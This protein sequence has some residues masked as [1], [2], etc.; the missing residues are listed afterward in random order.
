MLIALLAVL[1][2]LGPY[3]EPVGTTVATSEGL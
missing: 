2:V 3:L 1:A